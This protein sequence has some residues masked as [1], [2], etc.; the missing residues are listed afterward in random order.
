M[1]DQGRTF[2]RKKDI[3]IYALGICQKCRH[4]VSR[5]V[6][7]VID[8]ESLSPC[9]CPQCHD[10]TVH[11]EKLE[12]NHGVANWQK[13]AFRL[14]MWFLIIVAAL[15][16]GSYWYVEH[17]LRREYSPEEVRE[18]QHTVSAMSTAEILIAFQ[19]AGL[20]EESLSKI[21]GLSRFTLRR[22]KM[23]ETLP[24]PSMEA[25]FRG[26][27]TDWLL[28]GRSNLLFQLRY[29]RNG[30][31]QWYAFPNPLQEMTQTI[32]FNDRSRSSTQYAHMLRH[33]PAH[34]GAASDHSRRR[35][36]RFGVG[37]WAGEGRTYGGKPRG[38]P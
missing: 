21:L 16:M 22:L 10:G 7:A 26:M 20:S 30:Y 25:S 31:D 28:L 38:Y 34:G 8:E 14:I 11:F 6:N 4:V 24:T 33:R 23:G 13:K 15:S 17:R 36:Q 3:R 1:K 2:T 9:A 19:E 37:G 32:R 5:Q 27:Y 18:A 12:V 29:G 35:R